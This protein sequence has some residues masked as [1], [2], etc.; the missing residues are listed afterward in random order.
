RLRL[1]PQHLRQSLA[2][3]R[4]F[5]WRVRVVRALRAYCQ[6]TARH[7]RP[8][9]PRVLPAAAGSGAAAPAAAGRG[10]LPLLLLGRSPRSTRPSAL[11][12]SRDLPTYRNPPIIRLP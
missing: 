5:L 10:A 9:R 2:F 6:P 8:V 7:V 12:F 4:V 1:A 3:R 11:Y